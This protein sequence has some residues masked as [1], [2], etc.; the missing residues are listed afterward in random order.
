MTIQ[1]YRNNSK[2]KTVDK[3]S[4]LS[5]VLSADG[6][7]REE[8]SV[9]N[10]V[11][12]LQTTDS[13]QAVEANGEPVD[14]N[15][16]LIEYNYQISDTLPDFNYAYI[17][18]FHRYYFVT[19]IVSVRNGLWRIGMRVDVL[20]T[21]RAQFPWDKEFYAD[22]SEN[23]G[24]SLL[25]DPLVSFKD[26]ET[27]EVYELDGGNKKNFSFSVSSN[28]PNSRRITFVS[29]VDSAHRDHIAPI[30]AWPFGYEPWSNVAHSPDTD[31]L[32]DYAPNTQYLLTLCIPYAFS[33]NELP[34][35][36]YAIQFD[37]TKIA[38]ILS[39]VIW[40]FEFSLDWITN[41]SYLVGVAGSYPVSDMSTPVMRFGLNL[42]YLVLCNFMIPQTN[43]FLYNTAHARFEI[44]IPYVGWQVIDQNEL[45]AHNLMIYYSLSLIDGN[46]TAYLYDLTTHKTIL[47][48]PVQVGSKIGLTATNYREIR[49]QALSLGLNTGIGAVAGAVGAGAVS[50]LLGI[51][52][53]VGAIAKASIQAQSI[54]YRQ[55]AGYSNSNSASMSPLKSYLRITR[56]EPSV[57]PTSLT[58]M[59]TYGNP[60]KKEYRLKEYHGFTMIP[61]FKWESNGGYQPAPTKPE[62]EEVTSLFA[63]G[64]ILPYN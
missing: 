55:S 37:D 10:P 5:L 14:A 7:L 13:T 12:M 58:F 22:R 62:V 18:D 61:N 30:S 33:V 45:S 15:G 26:E 35:V 28:N 21:Y 29:Y 39:V 50:P 46:G 16:D 9:L 38:S 2:E 60:C 24:D 47:S 54:M 43:T 3:T 25:D 59:K 63:D 20:M 64:V 1:F 19:E 6:F 41:E 51:A 49:A 31:N 32:P 42:P 56:H 27:V 4:F 11:I 34:K 52:S 8:S 40:P 53:A 48:S 57:S 44:Y 36:Q 17:P 23:R